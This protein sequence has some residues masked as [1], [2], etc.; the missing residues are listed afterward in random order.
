MTT[1]WYT[2][3]IVLASILTVSGQEYC[4]DHD[5]DKC[6]KGSTGPGA[7]CTCPDTHAHLFR[8]NTFEEAAFLPKSAFPVCNSCVQCCEQFSI[9]V[10]QTGTLCLLGRASRFT[11]TSGT[12]KYM[13]S[14]GINCGCS[15]CSPGQKVKTEPSFDSDRECEAC[16]SNTYST[17]SNA[18]NCIA[19]PT[20]TKGEYI[21]YPDTSRNSKGECKECP[22]GKYT[23]AKTHRYQECTDHKACSDK[24]LKYVKAGGKET[25]TSCVACDSNT[26]MNEVDHFEEAC[27]PQTECDKG[28][29]ISGLSFKKTRAKCIKC[30]IGKYQDAERHQ[31]KCKPQTE[32]GKG[33]RIESATDAEKLETQLACIECEIGEYR[34]AATHSTTTCTKHDPCPEGTYF[35]GTTTDA[36]RECSP[37]EDGTYQDDNSHFKPACKL[38]QLCRAGEKSVGESKIAEQNC[39][40][41]EDHT[42]QT[43]SEHRNTTCI[44]QPTCSKGYYI[45][46]DTASEARSCTPCREHEFNP[47]VEHRVESGSNKTTPAVCTSCKEASYQDASQHR[48]AD[49][50]PQPPCPQGTSFFGSPKLK[51]QCIPCADGTYQDAAAHFI[52]ACIE[53]T[54]CA[55]G[56]QITAGS[57]DSKQE[58]RPC[59]PRTYQNETEH[60]EEACTQQPECPHWTEGVEYEL[61]TGNS[62]TQLG[63]CIPAV[64]NSVRDPPECSEYSLGDGADGSACSAVS[65]SAKR[66]CPARCGTCSPTGTEPPTTTT[67]QT[68]TTTE[69]EGV[70]S[71]GG[72]DDID[73][74]AGDDGGG[75]TAIGDGINDA[76]SS[77]GGPGQPNRNGTGSGGIAAGVVCGLLVLIAIGFFAFRWKRNE[78]THAV[79]NDIPYANESGGAPRRERIAAP[80]GGGNGN[81]RAPATMRQGGA[82]TVTNN[83]HYQHR[84]NTSTDDNDGVLYADMGD[85]DNQASTGSEVL[86]TAVETGGA[87]GD[88]V[89]YADM[90]DGDNRASTGGE[91]LYTAVEKG[92]TGSEGVLYADFGDGDGD[93]NRPA[94]PE[95][96]YTA[97]EKRRPPAGAGG[98]G[99]GGACQEEMLYANQAM[100][101]KGFSGDGEDDNAYDG[102]DI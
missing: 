91:V 93:S 44:E 64:C 2:A 7:T 65:A 11:P 27:K 99:G 101:V 28:E 34:D 29:Y 68:T 20:C 54:K 66:K 84:N 73:V 13:V 46:P 1:S 41:C 26:Y 71:D 88:G 48:V 49:C 61:S 69:T 31:A 83:N 78:D 9:P 92:G 36:G 95:V 35:V 38:Q 25:S 6:V 8:D 17:Q 40:S 57:T 60:R 72:A 22:D 10:K 47:D 58:C 37:C 33:E 94:S 14:C 89:L 4:G 15:T 62:K 52:T 43:H 50:L 19:Q 45:S 23:S 85:G 5:D 80:S 42:Y 51:G 32:C 98:G 3:T 18:G 21:E 77:E 74:N 55:A 59:G 102:L 90:G 87:G 81:A 56:E 67:T 70:S 79:I 30:D 53:Q 39:T 96:L 82:A 63:V 16:G 100:I 76:G 24:G 97:V 75:D 12:N 86:Y